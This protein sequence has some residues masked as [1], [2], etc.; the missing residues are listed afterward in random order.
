VRPLIISLAWRIESLIFEVK[1]SKTPDLPKFEMNRG[2]KHVRKT[3]KLLNYY[4]NK[5][6][7]IITHGSITHSSQDWKLISKIIETILSA[8]TI[9][10]IHIDK[11]STDMIIST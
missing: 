8:L 2:Q 5:S 10:G 4:V 11:T 1:R 9:K 6:E 7:L 3:L